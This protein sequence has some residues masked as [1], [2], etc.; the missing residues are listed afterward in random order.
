VT[1]AL[2]TANLEAVEALGVGVPHYDRGALAPRILHL[3][4]GGFHRAHLARYVDE[5][6]EAGRRTISTR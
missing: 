6:A 5:L 3:G 2:S 4:V 1:V